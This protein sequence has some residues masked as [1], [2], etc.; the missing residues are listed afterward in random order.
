MARARPVDYLLIYVLGGSGTVTMENRRRAARVGDLLCLVPGAAHAYGSS[1]DDP[2]DIVWVHFQGPLAAAFAD[3]IGRGSSRRVALGLDE[4]IRDR[5]VELVIAHHGKQPGHQ[6]RVDTGLCGLLGL[7]CYRL[8]QRQAAPASAD[9]LELPRLQRYVHDHLSRPI[10]LEELAG[11][12]HLS[13]T[14]FARVFKQQ[15]GVSPI[16]Y[17]IQT[18]LAQACALLVETD[19]SVKQVSVTVGYSDPYYFSRLFKKMIGQNPT[20]YRQRWRGGTSRATAV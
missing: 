11:L 9:P 13:P 2:W 14:H 15:F 8:Q 10:T 4:E 17:V 7:I 5:W 3:L 6:L 19:L 18:R 16:Y 1:R 20:S 12:V